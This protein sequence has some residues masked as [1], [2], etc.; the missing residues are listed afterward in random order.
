MEGQGCHCTLVAYIEDYLIVGIYAVV[1]PLYLGGRTLVAEPLQ[2]QL[3]VRILR[4]VVVVECRNARVGKLQS[5]GIGAIDI[6]EIGG[7]SKDVGAGEIVDSIRLAV[8]G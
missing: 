8:S 3:A 4:T 7:I 2:Q 5:T 6:G 1:Q